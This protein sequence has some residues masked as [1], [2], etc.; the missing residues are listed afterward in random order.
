MEYWKDGILKNWSGGV[1]EW[2]QKGKRYRVWGCQVSTIDQESLIIKLV[3][4]KRSKRNEV[5]PYDRR[6][7]VWM[8]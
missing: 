2:W 8:N 7:S 4:T 5:S 6:K 1:M 3:R